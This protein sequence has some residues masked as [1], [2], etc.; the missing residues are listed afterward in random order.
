M[1]CYAKQGAERDDGEDSVT[2]SVYII[3]KVKEI[4]LVTSSSY[5]LR[6]YK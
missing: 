3:N 4:T 5:S 1:N 2:E 6:W